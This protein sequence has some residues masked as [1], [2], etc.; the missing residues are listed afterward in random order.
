MT[1]IFSPSL[2][3]KTSQWLCIRRGS[4]R[5]AL[6]RQIDIGKLR[7]VEMDCEEAEHSGNGAGGRCIGSELMVRLR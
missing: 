6:I 4:Q 7:I 5:V 3:Q 1:G 2:P